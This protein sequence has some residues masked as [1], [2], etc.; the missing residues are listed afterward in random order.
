MITE[1]D[2]LEAGGRRGIDSVDTRALFDAVG[3]PML[4]CDDRRRY[5]DANA[6]ACATLGRSREEIVGTTVDELTP[7]ELRSDLDAAWQKFLRTGAMSGV[8]R[9]VLPGGKMA[10]FD[11]TAIAG[12]GDG[13]HLSVV[14]PA[15]R[16]S[17]QP[18]KAPQGSPLSA[19]EREIM[20][21]VALG[22]DGPEIAADLVV[23]PATVRT[24]IGNAIRKLGARSRAHAI[25]LALRG[26]LLDDL[27]AA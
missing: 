10:R 20:R 3:V 23:S 27:P 5:V 26:G 1:G 7:P 18:L 25:A 16:L 17:T 22:Q 13:R 8:F 6:A 12:V 11:Y 9:L 15:R 21:R 14:V 4:I 2:R 24:H 19:R